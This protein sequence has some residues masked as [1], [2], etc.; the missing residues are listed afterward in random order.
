MIKQELMT[1][2][3]QQQIAKN[4]YELTMEGELVQEMDE[5]GRFVHLRI[6]GGTAP[7]LRRP[8]SVAAVHQHLGQFTII[9]RAGGEGTRLLSEKKAGERIDVLGPLG[10]GFPLEAIESGQTA[11]L[12]GGGIGVPPLYDLS[13]RLKEKNVH[14]IHVLGFQNQE[15][16]FYMEKFCDLGET[17]MATEDG[18]LGIKGFVTDAIKQFSVKGDVLYACG[19]IPMLKALEKENPADRGF[20]SLE[21]RMGCGIGACFACVCHPSNDPKGTEYRKICSDGPVFPIGE[22]VL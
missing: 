6:N 20:V 8:I 13:R 3:S 18:S 12:V 15:S 21:Q 14:V 11:V 4:I 9:Y 22:V 10:H 5:P 1:I 2:V 7:L 17:Y 19:P 16:A